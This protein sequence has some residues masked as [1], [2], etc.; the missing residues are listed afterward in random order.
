ALASLCFGI[1]QFG[2]TTRERRI[3]V[4]PEVGL[5]MVALLTKQQP[6]YP[7]DSKWK[8]ALL[9]KLPEFVVK[10][11]PSKWIYNPNPHIKWSLTRD[12]VLVLI[13]FNVPERWYGQYTLLQIRSRIED[14][15]KRAGINEIYL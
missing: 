15:L 7:S 13:K 2:R 6:S 14:S 9:K 12:L 1:W 11:I 3:N 4:S 8:E 10:K 5:E